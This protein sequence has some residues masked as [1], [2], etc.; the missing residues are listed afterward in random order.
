MSRKTRSASGRLRPRTAA[1]KLALPERRALLFESLEKRELLA[2]G[3]PYNLIDSD[4]VVEVYSSGKAVDFSG[5]NATSTGT[6]KQF[7]A[8]PD[9]QAAT[10]TFSG[11]MTVGNQTIDGSFTLSEISASGG[12]DVQVGS[13]SLTFGSGAGVSLSGASGAFELLASGAAGVLNAAGSADSVSLSGLK[14]LQLTTTD[15]GLT[16][17]VNETGSAVH[18]SVGSTAI[19]LSDGQTFDVTGPSAFEV[20]T[21]TGTLARIGGNF[22]MTPASAGG[23][24]LSGQEVSVD[25]YAGSTDA[26]SVGSATAVFSLD[27][28]GLALV[29]NSFTVGGF[30][31][32]P[33]SPPEPGSGSYST[34]AK[35][36]SASLGPVSFQNVSPTLSSLSFS[37]T[38]LSVGVGLSAD[39][40]SLSFVKSGTSPDSGDESANVSVEGLNG[41]FELVGDVNSV[42]GHVSGLGASGAFS[43]TAD[44]FTFDIPRLL[45]ASASGLKFTYDPSISGSQQLF[46][47]QS[48][49]VSVPKLKLESTFKP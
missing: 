6:L 39:S 47:A 8:A 29:N 44:S 45:S 17:E 16:F 30:S 35:S 31:L 14:G 9:G 32:L 5:S 12:I 37:P 25:L 7:F 15:A 27:S 10:S 22:T 13:A 43:L 24:A 36:A 26:I 42:T 3:L 33:S 2:G 34:S 20:S 19:D 11:Q 4:T 21:D 40:A 1:R 48:V 18:D 28:S 41:S 46:S 49:T 23:L 38:K